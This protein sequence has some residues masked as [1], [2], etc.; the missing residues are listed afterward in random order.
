M[1]EAKRRKKLDP[2]WSKQNKV[3]KLALN[4]D[5]WQKNEAESLEHRFSDAKN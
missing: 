4:T 3:K 1:G 5:V 2:N